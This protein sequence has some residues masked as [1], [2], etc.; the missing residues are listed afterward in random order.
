[1][2]LTV[3]GEAKGVRVELDRPKRQPP[4]RVVLHLPK[5]RP[6]LNK[7]DG[8]EVVTRSDQT[9]RW[10]FPTVVRLYE[11]T[12]PKPKPIEGLVRMPLATPLKPDQCTLLDLKPLANTD[13]FTAPFGVPMPKGARL[14]FTGMPV[15]VRSVGG[16][17]FEIIDPA[18]NQGKGFIVL[19]SPRAPKTI[20]WPRQAEIQVGQKGKR[21][22]FL[23]NVH[24]WG[25][26][27][28]GAGEWDAVAEHVIHYADGK[29]QTA[30]VITGR[31]AEDWT[32]EPT[33]TEAWC[34][35]RGKPWHLNVVGVELRPV[36]VE[37]IVF[38]D[39]GT[40]AAPVLV[41]ITLER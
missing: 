22:F 24:G 40:A 30:P 18:K 28:P 23:G 33:A 15:G 7:L 41:A 4:K 16:V 1:M 5:S 34:G 32:L 2:G 31:T 6:L 10:D 25:S 20:P 12:R 26:T 19:H 8:V 14:L 39:M 29:T 3:R 9:K 37:K 36:R 35:L 27:D 11:E 13:P 21:L 17:P 38:R